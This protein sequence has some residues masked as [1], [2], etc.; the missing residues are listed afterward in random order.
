MHRFWFSAA[1]SVK[2]HRKWCTW[3]IFCPS[4]FVM[5]LK[6]IKKRNFRKKLEL[7]ARPS[8]WLFGTW[9]W[10]PRVWVYCI[11]QK[12]PI[13]TLESL[14]ERLQAVTARHRRI[15]FWWSFFLD[16]SQLEKARLRLCSWDKVAI[17]DARS[18]FTS[19]F[20]ARI[21]FSD[22]L[23]FFSF[24]QIKS[25]L[26][27]RESFSRTDSKCFQICNQDDG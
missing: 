27:I 26:K 8:K 20:L 5:A 1:S 23:L 18:V 4:C 22:F 3:K 19:F 7:S 14:Y 21:F 16:K 6:K 25:V 9:N 13:L 12:Q 15:V 24:D 11:I 2:G 17:Q 10:K